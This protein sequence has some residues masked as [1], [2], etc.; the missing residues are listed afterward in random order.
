LKKESLTLNKKKTQK[1]KKQNQI[2]YL[3]LN[4]KEPNILELTLKTY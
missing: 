3:S 1:I 2:I 4:K